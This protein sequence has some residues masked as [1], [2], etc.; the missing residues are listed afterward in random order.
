LRRPRPSLLALLRDTAESAE[1]RSVLAEVRAWLRQALADGPRPAGEVQSEARIM[2]FAFQTYRAARKAEGVTTRKAQ[3]LN[4]P[5]L[6]S[7]PEQ[8]PTDNKREQSSWVSSPLSSSLSL[9]GIYH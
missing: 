9:P 7:L 6:L 3:G 2:G 1:D 8:S 5:W 4:G